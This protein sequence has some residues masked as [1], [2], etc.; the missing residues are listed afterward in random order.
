MRPFLYEALPMRVRFAEHAVESL[1]EELAAVGGTKAVVVTTPEQ[2]ALGERVNAILGAAGGGVYPRAVMHVPA[3]AARAAR[4]HIADVGADAV[5]CVGGGST[6]GLGKAIALESDLP[7]IAVP[8][9]YAGSEMT[10]I[11]GLTENSVKRTGRDPRVLP[12]AVVY[13]PT[14]TVGLPV[15]VSVTSG[16]NAVAH[17]VEGLYAP[18]T[19]PMLS[20]MAAEG[21]ATMLRSLP[22][23]ASDPTDLDG[24]SEAL[25][26]AW[27]CGAVLGAT[28]MGLH[29][30]LCH[31]LGGTFDLPHAE[32]HAVVLPYVMAFNLPAA[33]DAQA[34]LVR[35]TGS[36]S[37]A[38]LVRE[39]ALQLGVPDS[40]AAIGMPEHGIGEVVR[41]A[42]DAPYSNP[43][44]VSKRDLTILLE[45]AYA[46]AALPDIATEETP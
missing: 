40:L 20:L 45:A 2:V 22:S 21:V 10:P 19:S 34:A 17:A 13:D 3:D 16:I 33:P 38:R 26:A 37:P 18:D 14:L 39:T 27:L 46:G 32:T 5:V 8:T 15:A 7:I 9:T 31:I 36:P 43:R 30:K 1:P 35:A 6:T 12:R 4:A 44:P 41:Q 42:A 25:Y 24:R 23:V 28:T 29:H 11:W